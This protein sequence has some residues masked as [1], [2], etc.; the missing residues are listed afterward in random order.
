MKRLRSAVERIFEVVT[1]GLLVVLAVEVL[2]G[3]V[4]RAFRRPLVW[5]DE[6][7]SVLLAWLTYYGSALAALK[8]AHIGFPGFVR[9]MPR[10]PRTAALVVR[11]IAVTGFFLLLAWE[12]ARIL[13]ELGGE[14]LVTVDIPVRLTQS[15]IPVG[16]V[17]FIVAELLTLPERIR[18]AR[19]EAAPPSD[20]DKASKE[21]AH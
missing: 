12:G 4:F 14:T 20:V 18:E 13:G 16:A 17:L 11:E 2:A 8:R 7:A 6:V 9:A 5:Y 1:V 3:I 21:L 15:V 10:A 19:G